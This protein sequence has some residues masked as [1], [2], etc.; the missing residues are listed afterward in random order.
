MPM[1]SFGKI[2]LRRELCR[3]YVHRDDG[4]VALRSGG[5]QQTQMTFMEGAHRR[6]ESHAFAGSPGVDDCLAHRLTVGQHLDAR[7]AA[8]VGITAYL[9]RGL[10]SSSM[11]E[12]GGARV[13]RTEQRRDP[14]LPTSF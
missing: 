8:V 6:N 4:Q 13:N 9:G 11:H 14:R 2:F 3:V 5:F 1:K 10:R 12:W 7:L